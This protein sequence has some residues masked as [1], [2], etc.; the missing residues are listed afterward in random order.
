MKARYEKQLGELKGELKSLKTARREHAKAMKENVSV[1]PPP[2][3][4]FS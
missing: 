1:I 3:L 2:Y 4:M